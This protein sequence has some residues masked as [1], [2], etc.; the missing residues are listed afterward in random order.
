MAIYKTESWTGSKGGTILAEM[1]SFCS[2]ISIFMVEDNYVNGMS[3]AMASCPQMTLKSWPV[4]N[5]EYLCFT[6]V[7]DPHSM[8]E[9]KERHVQ[10][11]LASPRPTIHI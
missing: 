11:K 3:S 8:E 10:I 6:L 7:P 5:G 9:Y 4:V 1:L 2:V